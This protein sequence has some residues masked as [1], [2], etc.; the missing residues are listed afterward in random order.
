MLVTWRLRLRVSGG[1]RARVRRHWF[2]AKGPRRW[3][4]PQASRDHV[5]RLT[6]KSIDEWNTT[7]ADTH[8]MT[9]WKALL[10]EHGDFLRE[11][12]AMAAARLMEAET[13]GRLAPR[14]CPTAA[15]RAM[16]IIDKQHDLMAPT[17][18][19]ARFDSLV[20]Q[21]FWELGGIGAGWSCGRSAIGVAASAISWLLCV[22]LGLSGESVLGD[23]L[24]VVLRFWV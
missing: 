13:A 14:P 21:R 12:V 19:A 22:W 10:E 4:D 20:G 1:G 24:I 8:S 17:G 11:A 3:R 15:G 7:M 6:P 9:S 23:S 18:A 16:R 2:R 5:R